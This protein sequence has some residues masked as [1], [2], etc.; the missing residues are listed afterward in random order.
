MNTER[1]LKVYTGKGPHVGK[2]VL[3]AATWHNADERIRAFETKAEAKAALANDAAERGNQA[4]AKKQPAK[5]TAPESSETREAV[6]WLLT[7]KL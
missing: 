7:M 2:F 4:K 6:L 3:K 5:Q 1:R